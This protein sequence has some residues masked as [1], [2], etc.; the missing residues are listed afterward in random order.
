MAKDE[1]STADKGKG[2]VEDRKELSGGKKENTKLINGKKDGH[3]E[4]GMVVI[5]CIY[6]VCG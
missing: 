1:R 5:G 4:E 6:Q 3:A 2:K